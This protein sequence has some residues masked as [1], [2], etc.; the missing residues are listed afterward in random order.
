MVRK[1]FLPFLALLGALFGLYVVAWS[2]RK[3]P[4]PPIAFQPARSPY[5]HFIAGSGLIE[6]SS[7]NIA[8]ASPFTETIE[9]VYV[10]EGDIVQA[11]DP[12][13]KLDTR[14]LEAQLE[15]SYASL[16][17][18]RVA[19]ED[20]KVQ[21]SFYK[22]LKDAKSVSEQAFESARYAYLN[23]EANVKVLEANVKEIEVN[24]A[25]STVR[26]P[27]SG[28]ILQANVIEGEIAPSIPPSASQSTWMVAT[29]GNLILMGAVL[30]LQ[31][32]IDIDETNAWRFEKGSRATAFVRGNSAVN[33][34]LTFKRIEP[35]VIPKSSF[36]GATTER[37]DT[38]VLQVLYTFKKNNIP[39]YVGQILDVFIEAKPSH[40]S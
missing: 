30:P 2:E 9:K 1:Y 28:E 21:F 20:K 33:F 36:T 19:L 39:V 8:V 22:R 12:L 38:R 29:Q 15:A 26:A 5:T 23:A 13:F 25:R 31:V 4:V 40:S 16:E 6:A 24:I 14:N 10:I 3:V 35:Y 32:R 17:A 27:I 7:K 11:N 37:V 34:P 18:A